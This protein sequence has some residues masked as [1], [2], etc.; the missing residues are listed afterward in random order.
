MVCIWHFGA[1]LWL[2]QG[3]Q[4]VCK[5]LPVAVGASL[6]SELPIHSLCGS[7]VSGGAD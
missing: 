7:G 6:S 4:L 3:L 5:I 1:L 2:R